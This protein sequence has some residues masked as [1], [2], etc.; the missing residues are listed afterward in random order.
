MSPRKA[1]EV[2]KI[3]EEFIAMVE[4]RCKN[5]SNYGIKTKENVTTKELKNFYELYDYRCMVRFLQEA[6]VKPLFEYLKLSNPLFVNIESWDDLKKISD[7]IDTE[8]KN[9]FEPGEHTYEEE[10]HYGITAR[11]N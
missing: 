1:N 4:S 10:D 3:I 2:D 9:V 6:K 8:I 7:L 11:I 5:F